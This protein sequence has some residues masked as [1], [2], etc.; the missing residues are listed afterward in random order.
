[1]TDLSPSIPVAE[2]EFGVDQEWRGGNRHCGRAH[3]HAINYLR[4][5][6]DPDVDVTAA[7]YLALAEE[8]W[9]MDLDNLR[10]QSETGL[11]KVRRG[12]AEMRYHW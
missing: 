2:W 8:A 6:A 5:Y 9:S 10:S 12:W 7:G 4:D 11:G 3:V 1:M